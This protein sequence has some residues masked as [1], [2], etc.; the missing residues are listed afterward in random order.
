MEKLELIEQF[1]IRYGSDLNPEVYS[2]K[3]CQSTST[4][5]IELHFNN[6]SH[7]EIIDL[8]FMGGEIIKDENGMDEDILPLF[9]PEADIVDNAKSFIELDPYGLLI[10]VDHLFTDSAIQKILE[11]YSNNT[12]FN[13]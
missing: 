4:T 1:R 10:C 5:C 6:T 13:Q 7:P 2:L 12:S 9:N 3:Y 8:K 11:E